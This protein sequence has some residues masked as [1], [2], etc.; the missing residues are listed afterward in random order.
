MILPSTA[1]LLL[2]VLTSLA[3]STPLR[4]STAL[5]QP[6]TNT[7]TL[8]R[9]GKTTDPWHFC[10]NKNWSSFGERAFLAG[11][12]LMGKTDD[13][14]MRLDKEAREQI[15][16]Y[17][18]GV[19]GMCENLWCGGNHS[20]GRG[21][22]F[23]LCLHDTT[24]DGPYL[25]GDLAQ[26]FHDGFYDC[27]GE[28]EPQDDP[29]NKSLAFHVWEAGYDLH[30]EGGKECSSDSLLIEERC[31]VVLSRDRPLAALVRYKN[32]S[33]QAQLSKADCGT[34]VYRPERRVSIE[35]GT[36]E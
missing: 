33:K 15:P 31:H 23:Y 36:V 30:V 19:R 4:E 22:V 21:V 26:K 16:D 29:D 27:N 2:G 12:R 34:A 7:T 1:A 13:R 17:Y 10:S 28:R 5:D 14:Q 32:S 24:P 25:S 9:R 18:M 11:L 3:A 8:E 6:Y 20:K 35:T